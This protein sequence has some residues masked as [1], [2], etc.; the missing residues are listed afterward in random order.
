MKKEPIG[1]FFILGSYFF[2]DLPLASGVFNFT[3]CGFVLSITFSHSCLQPIITMI[4]VIDWRVGDVCVDIVWN[5][6]FIIF[7][8]KKRFIS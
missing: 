2:S 6:L 4:S 5:M 7:L 8:N 3:F 1:S